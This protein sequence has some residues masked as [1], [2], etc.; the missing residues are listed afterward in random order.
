MSSVTLILSS[1]SSS[2]KLFFLFPINVECFLL[3]S[4]LPSTEAAS[5]SFLISFAKSKWHALSCSSF[6]IPTKEQ[7][8]VCHNVITEGGH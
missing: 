2:T 7:V 1:S 3:F 8:Y 6:T 4:P 5:L